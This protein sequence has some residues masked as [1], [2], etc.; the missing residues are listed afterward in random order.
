MRLS[1]WMLTAGMALLGGAA[2]YYQGVWYVGTMGGMPL[3]AVCGP[4]SGACIMTCMQHNATGF[5]RLVAPHCT[6]VSMMWAAGAKMYWQRPAMYFGAL[7][8]GK[9][10][11]L[12][13]MNDSACKHMHR[14]STCQLCAHPLHVRPSCGA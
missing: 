13:G 3:E 4:Q 6:D 12:W 2:G 1:N 9:T 5:Q 8:L 10:G 14:H 11:L 7:L